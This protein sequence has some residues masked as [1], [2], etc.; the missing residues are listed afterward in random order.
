MTDPMFEVKVVNA[1]NKSVIRTFTCDNEE[2]AIQMHNTYMLEFAG[3]ESGL[4][5][6]Q[7]SESYTLLHHETRLKVGN[8][9]E[10]VISFKRSSPPREEKSRKI[11]EDLDIGKMTIKDETKSEMVD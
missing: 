7:R 5:V 4:L 1:E 8:I 3:R 10:V 9:G 6:F 2:E 11:E